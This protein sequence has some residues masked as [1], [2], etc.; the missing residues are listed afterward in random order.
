M[1]SSTPEHV[2]IA[3][4]LAKPGGATSFAASLAT[5]LHGQGKRVTVLAGEGEWLFQECKKIGI[6][7]L[8]VTSLGREIHPWHDLRSLWQLV[9]LLRALKPDVL[10]LNSSKM[11]VL[12][13]L[14]GRLARVP[15]I[16]Y[17]I[18][19]WSFLESLPERT[20]A[21][22]IWA[23]RFSGPW[24]DRIICLHPGDAEEAAK[25]RIKSREPLQVIPNGIPIALLDHRRLSREEAR[26]ALGLPRDGYLYGTIGN[27][28][29]AKD[30]PRYLEACALVHREHPGTRFALIGDGQ[31]R[32]LIESARD[33]LDLREIVYLLGSREEASRYLLAFD[34]FVLPSTKE[35]MAFALLEAMAAGLPCITTDV[36]ANRWVLGET[37]WIVPPQNPIALA[38]AMSDAY[39]QRLRATEKGLRARK[40][41]ETRFPIEETLR[42]HEAALFP[43]SF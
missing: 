33:R 42:A 41:V 12:G 26:A 19:G 43:S 6:S 40:T 35:G 29:P 16:V 24:K 23:E 30:L 34:S 38:R 4:T 1:P 25:H 21:F 8:R 3:I 7:C 5:F 32:S 27:F 10:Q 39:K 9:H 20:K 22:Y 36:G 14:A 15:R 18:G 13:S 2:V 17:C 11:G 37:G 31:E 28:Y